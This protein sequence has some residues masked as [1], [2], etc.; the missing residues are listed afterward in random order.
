MLR[1]AKKRSKRLGVAFA[2]EKSDIVVPAVCP[3]FG[4]PLVP[5]KDHSNNNSPSIDRLIPELGYTKGNISVISWK[6]NQLKGKATTAAELETRARRTKNR[7]T[8][9]EL[10]KVARW[11][12]A[13]VAA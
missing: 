12:R 4:A 2:L 13:R 11:L 10:E 6:A 3:V 8:A 9:E 1:D 5:G 7:A